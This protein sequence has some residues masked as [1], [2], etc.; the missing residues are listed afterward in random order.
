LELR[1]GA[2]AGFYYL[3]FRK[4]L[5]PKTQETGFSPLEKLLS[6]QINFLKVRSFHPDNSGAENFCAGKIRSEWSGPEGLK[7]LG[8]RREN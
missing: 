6:G 1:N 8:L 2:A 5:A 7:D 4:W 3:D